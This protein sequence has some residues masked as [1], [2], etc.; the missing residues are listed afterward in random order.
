VAQIK[1]QTKMTGTATKNKGKSFL[2]VAFG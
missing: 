2:W 1:Q